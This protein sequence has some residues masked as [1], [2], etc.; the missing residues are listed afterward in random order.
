MVEIFTNFGYKFFMRAVFPGFLIVVI[1]VSL[2]FSCLQDVMRSLV[3]LIPI[4]FISGIVIFM[5]DPFIYIYFEGRCLAK[6]WPWLHQKI[7][8][9][10]KQRVRKMYNEAIQLK[11]K[12]SNTH[13]KYLELRFW[14]RYFPIDENG[15][16]TATQPTLIGNIL[17]AAESYPIIKYGMNPIFYFYRLWI[18]LDKDTRSEIDLNASYMDGVIYTKFVLRMATFF[19]LLLFI[20]NKL[21]ILHLFYD[22]PL[23]IYCIA[24]FIL[25]HL[26][27]FISIPLVQAKG[28]YFKSMFDVYRD[29]ISGMGK[30]SSEVDERK[31]W[32][33]IFKK[34]QSMP[35]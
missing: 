27:H 18:A 3:I 2:L 19:Y 35:D 13:P 22:K 9:Y 21:N 16:P 29:K 1:I 34:L 5:M 12:F 30:I 11:N 14:L 24:S 23:G 25:C 4:W 31:R 20:L 26:F 8:S 32:E 6:T 33:D 28:E 15:E 17:A 7:T 10:H